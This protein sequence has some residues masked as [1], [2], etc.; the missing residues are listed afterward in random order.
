MTITIPSDEALGLQI[1]RIISA[2]ALVAVAF[3]VAGYTLGT[4]VHELNASLTRLPA[5]LPTITPVLHDS[6][7]PLVLA[8]H[9]NDRPGPR[10]SRQSQPQSSRSGVGFA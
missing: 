9:G 7:H 10:R 6:T 5:A 3:Y 8:A 1:K 2:V 4:A